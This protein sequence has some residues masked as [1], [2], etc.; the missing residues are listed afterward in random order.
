V[1]EQ[2]NDREARRA[3]RELR[4]AQRR[5]NYGSIYGS[6]LPGIIL[7][8]LGGIFLTQ[9][10]FG[11]TLRNWW[12]LFILIPAFSALTTAYALW[13]DGRGQWATGPLLAG[14]GFVALTAIFLLDVPI[15]QL[16]PVFLIV[17]GLGLLLSRGRSGWY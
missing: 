9:N 11:T 6:W 5:A 1:T 2:P 16:W 12:A 8:L 4:R 14:L 15:G 7:I 10:Y 17:A 13:R 3:D